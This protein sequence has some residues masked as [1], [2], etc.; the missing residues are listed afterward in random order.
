MI[1]PWAKYLPSPNQSSRDGWE[2]NAVVIHC[3]S[4]PPGAFSGAWVEN[5]FLNR[6]D[7]SAHPYFAEIANIKVSSHF[8]ITRLGDVVQF[9]E[10][11]AKAW[12]AGESNLNGVPDVNRFSIGIELEGDMTTPYSEEQ[13]KI[14]VELIKWIFKV[15]PATTIDRIVGHDHIS[16]GRKADPGPLFDWERLRRETSNPN[17]S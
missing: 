14:L 17:I 15:H 8:F 4:L 3:I 11:D 12:H 7:A 6:L 5:F 9:V 13:Y 2:V 1:L 10:T 16:P